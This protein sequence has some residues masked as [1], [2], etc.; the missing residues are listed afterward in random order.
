MTSHPNLYQACQSDPNILN[1]ISRIFDTKAAFTK[2]LTYPDYPTIVSPP[3]PIY[4][5][6]TQISPPIPYR[7][8]AY[9]KGGYENKKKDPIADFLVE[10]PCPKPTEKPPRK[11]VVKVPCPKP[12]YEKPHQQNCGCQTCSCNPCQSYKK[13]S[14]EKDSYKEDSY[15]KDSYEKESYKADTY[16]KDS[17]E[18]E[19]Y[20]PEP[21]EKGAYKPEP[22]KKESYKPEPYKPDPYKK[23]AYKPEPYKPEPAPYQSEEDG[24]MK[25]YT[26]KKHNEVRHP[27]KVYRPHKSEEDSYEEEEPKYPS[28]PPKKVYRIQAYP[29]KY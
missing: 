8:G 9:S 10:V 14:Y 5:P 17:Y 18:K 20:K 21:Y 23:D 26:P 28:P 15:K 4:P 13:D 16:K 27:Y 24:Y 1:A 22:Y 7:A 25:K 3:K 29:Q 2:A 12:R 6:N 11:I 19:S